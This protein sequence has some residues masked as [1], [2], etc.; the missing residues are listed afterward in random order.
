[1]TRRNDDEREQR[2]EPDLV[3]QMS[4]SIIEDPRS[5]SAGSAARAIVEESPMLNLPA[6]PSDLRLPVGVELG[7]PRLVPDLAGVVALSV[8]GSYQ[9]QT[10]D[11]RILLPPQRSARTPVVVFLPVNTGISGP[12]GCPLKELLRLRLAERLGIIAVLPA[13]DNDPWMGDLPAAPADGRPWVRQRALVHEVLLPLVDAWL[14]PGAAGARYLVGFSKS[15]PAALAMA[16]EHRHLWSGVGLY[17]NAEPAIIDERFETWGLAIVYGNRDHYLASGPLAVL[18][19]I[20]EFEPDSPLRVVIAAGSP[21]Y[22]GVNSLRQALTAVGVDHDTQ[23]HPGMDH[24][25]DAGWLEGVL[26]SLIPSGLGSAP[27]G[28]A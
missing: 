17:D 26:L 5:G 18:E 12:W 8:G 15:G 27:N 11:V 20:D 1:M 16:I 21:D 23:I 13:Y 2:F 24:R 9:R 25:W 6:L 10:N 22:Y 4:L 28:V 3:L 14:R 19:R 7:F